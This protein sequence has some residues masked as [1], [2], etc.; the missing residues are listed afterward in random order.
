V[1]ASAE[2]VAAWRRQPL[3]LAGE[4]LPASFLKHSEDQTITGLHALQQALQRAGLPTDAF[5]AWGVLAAPTFLGRFAMALSLGRYLQ[6]GA[7]GVS[8]NLIPHHSL[9]GLSG[10]I[11]QALKIH[12]PNFGAGDGPGGHRDAFLLAA[13]LLA[14]GCADG[15]LPGLWL[16]LTGHESEAIPPLDQ[17][18]GTPACLAVVLALVGS[19]HPPAGPRLGIGQGPE[20]SGEFHLGA[21]L[22]D[23]AHGKWRLSD[24]HW[25]EVD[26][27]IAA[28]VQG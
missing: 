28:E 26:T 21:L 25:L 8:P 6:E 3:A 1:R 20:Q 14:D 15:T 19:P 12:G 22:T 13:G 9:H 11:S 27:R 4:S 16:V 7:W 18:T 10:T 17:P 24:S 23:E 5:S 2:Q